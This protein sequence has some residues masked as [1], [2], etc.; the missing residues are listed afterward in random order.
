MGQGA[1]DLGAYEAVFDPYDAEES[2][3]FEIW[4]GKACSY[5]VS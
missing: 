2:K 3:G 4:Q 5:K 1:E